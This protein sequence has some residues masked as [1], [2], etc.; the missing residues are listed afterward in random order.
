MPA[1][2]QVPP[3]LRSFSPAPM[4]TGALTLR[5]G[6]WWGGAALLPMAAEGPSVVTQRSGLWVGCLCRLVPAP[7]HQV[8]GIVGIGDGSFDGFA[9]VE[10]SEAEGEVVV[11]P[12]PTYDLYGVIATGRIGCEWVVVAERIDADRIGTHQFQYRAV[13]G[14]LLVNDPVDRVSQC[15]VAVKG[16]YA[17]RNAID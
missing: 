1:P 7:D 16:Q 14:I 5:R 4:N 12:V 3:G 17:T 13:F 10:T 9:G 2:V 11:G 6:N 15:K 8:A